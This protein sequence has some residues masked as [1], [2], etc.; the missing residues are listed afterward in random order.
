MGNLIETPKI[1]PIEISGGNSLDPRLTILRD[2]QQRMSVK[3]VKPV[4][5]PAA[6]GKGAGLLAWGSAV[7]DSLNALASIN[8][9]DSAMR[10]QRMNTALSKSQNL[11]RANLAPERINMMAQ[12]TPTMAINNEADKLNKKPLVGTPEQ[13]TN[14][15]ANMMITPPSMA[16]KGLKLVKRND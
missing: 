3:P 7:G 1:E 4:K 15:P 2:A 10:E 16:K 11:L 6:G 13:I 9:T 12:V 14:R 8:S 5:Q